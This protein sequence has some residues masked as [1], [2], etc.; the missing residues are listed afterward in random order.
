MSGGLERIVL[1]GQTGGSESLARFE[2]V[3]DPRIGQN[4]SRVL[5]I[6]F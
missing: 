4:V 6:R 3:S 5:L 1:Q 2:T